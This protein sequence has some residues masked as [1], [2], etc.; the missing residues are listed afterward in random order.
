[1]DTAA[2]QRERENRD[3]LEKVSFVRDRAAAAW[4][5]DCALLDAVSLL[6]KPRASFGESK[7]ER[8]SRR[9]P[10]GRA[11]DSRLARRCCCSHLR[12]CA[13][14]LPHARKEL[15]SEV[16]LSCRS[17]SPQDKARPRARAPLLVLADGRAGAGAFTAR[18][19]PGQVTGR[20]REQDVR[21]RRR[22]ARTSSRSFFLAGLSD[23]TAGFIWIW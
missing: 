14:E 13:R 4:P 17:R 22:C 9:S 23:S 16:K 3:Q 7:R 20:S 18:S 1:M 19:T 8:I 12:P 15:S 10:S 2:E 5:T 6:G 21:L 11:R